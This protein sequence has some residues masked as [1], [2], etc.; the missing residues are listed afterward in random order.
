MTKTG[1]LALDVRS[2]THATGPESAGDVPTDPRVA[3]VKASKASKTVLQGREHVQSHCSS[4]LTFDYMSDFDQNSHLALDVRSVTHTMGPD[5]A[6]NVPLDPSWTFV[7]ALKASKTILQGRDHVQ[8]HCLRI[9]QFIIRTIL[10]KTCHLALDV[11]SV[12]HATGSDS[13]GDVPTDPRGA[14]V[15]AL[16]QVRQFSTAVTTFSCTVFASDSSLL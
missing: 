8:L 16:K 15:K 1:H 9:G 12:T 11:R 13:A 10:T 14:Y 4:K 3:Y 5:S 7:M 2:V 6:G